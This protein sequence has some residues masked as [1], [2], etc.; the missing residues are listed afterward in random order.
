MLRA[1]QLLHSPTVR[2][3]RSLIELLALDD[4]HTRTTLQFVSRQIAAAMPVANQ[5]P[6]IGHDPIDFIFGGQ[7]LNTRATPSGTEEKSRVALPTLRH[8]G[9]APDGPSSLPYLSAVGGMCCSSTVATTPPKDQAA[10]SACA[11]RVSGHLLRYAEELETQAV[12][13]D[14]RAKEGG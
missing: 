8:H 6:R 3:L 7:C 10:A 1:M 13:M 2:R 9:H 14:R 4:N 11:P 5:Q 12:D